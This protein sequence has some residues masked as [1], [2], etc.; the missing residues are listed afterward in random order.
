MKNSKHLIKMG[1]PFAEEK[2][3]NKYVNVRM[4]TNLVDKVKK[5]AI[6]DDMTLSSVIRSILKKHFESNK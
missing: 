2:E 3:E 5:Q 4:P 6:R 1:D